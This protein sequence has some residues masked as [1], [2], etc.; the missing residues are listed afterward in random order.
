MHA[1]PQITR[2]C[3]STS[4]EK[5]RRFSLKLGYDGTGDAALTQGMT[6][7]L[8]LELSMPQTSMWARQLRAAPRLPKMKSTARVLT[9]TALDWH[10]R[11]LGLTKS[12]CPSFA[13]LGS[14]N[15]IIGL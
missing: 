3:R 11:R 10:R 4:A 8:S 15:F 7:C 1:S 14:G 9:V 12:S 5:A 6:R 2:L 13:E